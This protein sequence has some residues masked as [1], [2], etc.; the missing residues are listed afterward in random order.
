MIKSCLDFPVYITYLQI[1]P[2]CNNIQQLVLIH[3]IPEQDGQ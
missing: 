3:G 2:L 1:S